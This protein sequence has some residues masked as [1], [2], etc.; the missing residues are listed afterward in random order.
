M[1]VNWIIRNMKKLWKSV[2]QAQMNQAIR[3]IKL[4]SNLSQREINE[5]VNNARKYS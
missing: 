2:K 5:L 3:E 1:L 4:Y